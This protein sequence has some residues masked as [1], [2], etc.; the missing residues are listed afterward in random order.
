M[1]YDDILLSDLIKIYEK[2]DANS[3]CLK[4][5]VKIKLTK[6]KYPKYFENRI[7]FDEAIERLLVLN[8]IFAK[9]IPHDTVIDFIY[10]NLDKVDDI[11]ERLGIYAV[12]EKRN[13]LLIELSKY[14]DLLI[15]KINSFINER[16]ENKKSIKQFLNDDYIDAIKAVH[17]LENLDHDVYERN[18]SNYIF[19]DSKRLSSIKSTLNSIYQTDDVYK[20]K[21]IM[22]IA[23]Y[24]Y[25]KGEG[26]V[27]VN[28][29]KINLSLL[30]TSIGLPIDDVSILNFENVFKVTTIENLTTFHDYESDGLIIYLGGFATRKQIEV[31]KLIKSKCENF[32]H[33]GDIDYGGFTIL[34]NL[35]EQLN[36]DIKTIKM[37]ICTLKENIRFA[38]KFDDSGY[39]KKLES[40]LTKPLLKQWYDV[41]EYLIANKLWLEQESFYNV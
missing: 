4:N 15:K 11:K 9:K 17:Y 20:E 2:R 27:S 32:Y 29:E 6:E 12:S 31:L 13:Q 22:T 41:I 34:N 37:D 5:K 23:P 18:A 40:L 21:G 38:Q 30:K 36:I 19:N 14:D 39:I 33:F 1:T 35:I 10:L 26:I 3:S 24:L 7:E 16:I 25:V 28:K 8:Y